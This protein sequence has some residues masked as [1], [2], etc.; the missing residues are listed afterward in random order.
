MKIN[1]RK[2][3]SA[4]TL[5]EVL[6]IVAVLAILVVLL[7]PALYSPVGYAPRTQCV[8]NLKQIGLGFR[9]WAKDHNSKFPMGIPIN[10]RGT[11]E[12]IT[13]GEAFRHFQA[14]SNELL[15]TRLLACPADIRQ[16]AENYAVIRSTNISYFVG[17]DASEVYPATFLCGDRNLTNGTPLTN[18]ILELTSKNVV[19]WTAEM[20]NEQGNILLSD[21][22]VQSLSSAKLREALQATGIGTNRLAMPLD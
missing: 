2:L 9:M 8:N 14:L 15:T 22:S 10:E 1:Q 17:L 21:G 7:L 6:V 16:P 5:T 11:Q 3:E 18:G 12:W 20:H 4:L 19:G 13:T